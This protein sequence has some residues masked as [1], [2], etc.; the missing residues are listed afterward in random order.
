MSKEILNKAKDRFGTERDVRTDSSGRFGTSYEF[1]DA[2]ATGRATLTRAQE[3]T[4]ITGIAA[5]H[6][7][8]VTVT[9][10]NTSGVAQQIDI[11]MATGGGVQDTILVAATGVTTKSYQLP[12]MTDEVATT[13]TAQ[14][15][16]TGESSDSPV[17]I[18]A[19]AYKT[20]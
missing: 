2:T 13:I 10:V 16:T 17:T 18:T 15:S 6:F 9:G 14:N 5:T 4:I 19:I 1:R 3:T 7:G 11:R 8:L 12:L 20:T